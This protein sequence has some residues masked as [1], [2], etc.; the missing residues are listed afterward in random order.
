[1]GKW[2]FVLIL[3]SGGGW[4]Y[5][6]FFY[7]S[8]AYLTY[9]AFEEAAADGDCDKLMTM[10]E[11]QAKEWIQDY[12]SP[13]GGKASLVAGLK[14]TPEGKLLRSRHDLVSE[15]VAQDG[16]IDL[17]FMEVSTYQGVR[18]QT[19]APEKHEAKLKLVGEAWKLITYKVSH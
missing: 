18:F 5:W 11:G 1:M 9:V 8:P 7:K 14:G 15:T 13:N 4:A 16:S 10:V 19:P 2:I 12:C 6:H 17:I 3:A